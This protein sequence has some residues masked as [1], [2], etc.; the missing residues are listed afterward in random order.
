MYSRCTIK[1]YLH[2]IQPSSPF[3]ACSCVAKNSQPQA[4]HPTKLAT[5]NNHL[6][7]VIYSRPASIAIPQSR[8]QS[9][10]A[11]LWLSRHMHACILKR[12]RAIP[13]FDPVCRC[14]GRHWFRARA[15][16]FEA[17]NSKLNL[18]HSRRSQSSY[19]SVCAPGLDREV[20]ELSGTRALTTAW[21]S[22]NPGCL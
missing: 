10:T 11:M 1:N 18:R 8:I 21:P 4:R 9:N 22:R 5:T 13:R 20:N 15:R 3:L 14:N 12:G 17:R 7:L 16:S 6:S 2:R 19:I